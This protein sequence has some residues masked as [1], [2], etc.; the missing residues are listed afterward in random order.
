MAQHP[1]ER[2]TVIPILF[3]E[4]AGA[5]MAW[6]EK[7][8]GFEPRLSVTDDKGTVVH[9]EMSYGD[10]RIMIGPAGWTDW[11]KSP[12]AQGGVS[13]GSVHVM[14][15][16]VDIHCAKARAAGAAITME[17]ED[18]FYGDR[19]YRVRDPEGHNWTFSHHVRDVSEEEMEAATGLKV[20][21]R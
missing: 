16:D 18:Q 2:S 3:Y 19:A 10:G 5:A 21:S 20:E 9:G 17:P 15:D 14:V 6:L 4:D 13:M 11:A 7:A 8:F 1:S 12:K